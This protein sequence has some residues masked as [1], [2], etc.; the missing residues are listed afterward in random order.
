LREKEGSAESREE[1]NT[2]IPQDGELKMKT[3]KKTLKLQKS[4]RNTNPRRAD[5]R[6]SVECICPRCGIRHR[7][8][9]YWSG[10][11]IPKK[12]CIVCKGIIASFDPSD[13]CN[14]PPN[15][16]IQG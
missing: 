12:Y 6:T 2:A 16:V 9:F 13:A 3:A 8:S 11:G 4:G 7:L 5:E 1:A 15:I 10:R 14:L